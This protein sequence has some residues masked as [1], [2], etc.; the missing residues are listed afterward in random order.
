MTFVAALRWCFAVL[1]ASLCA[2]P[3]GSVRVAAQDVG[4]EAAA[5]IGQGALSP[6]LFAVPRR[7]R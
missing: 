4:T 3:M 5:G 7:E 1:V 6:K 2:V